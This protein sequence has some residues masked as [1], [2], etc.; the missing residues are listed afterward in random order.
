MKRFALGSSAAVSTALLWVAPLC[1]IAGATAGIVSDRWDWVPLTLLS[2]GAGALLLWLILQSRVSGGFWGRRST[3]MSTNAILTVVAVIALLGVVNVLGN[4][5]SVDIDLTENQ[6]FTL[7]VETRDVLQNLKEPVQVLVFDTNAASRDRLLLEQYRRHANNRF[8]F[9]FVDPQ[10][11]P[12]LAR[13]YN[14]TQVGQVIVKAGTKTQRIDEDLSES[15]LTPALIRVTSDRTVTAYFTT[16]HNELPLTGGSASLSEVAKLLEQR[17][18]ELLPLNLLEKGKVPEDANVIVVAGPRQPFLRLEEDLLK[19]YLNRG[20]SLLLMLDV[21]VNVGLADLLK[22]WGLTL[23]NRWVIDGS[24]VGQQVGL[25]PDTIIVTTYG[26]H[27]ITQRFAQ[28]PSVFPRAQAIRI[29]P[30]KDDDIVELALSGSQTWAETDWQSGNLEFTEGVDTLGPLPLAVAITRTLSEEP[31]KQARLVVFGDSEFATDGVIAYQ[32]INS[33]L[34][35]NS[36]LWLGDRDQQALSLR[37][38]Q[39]TNRRLQLNVTTSRWIEISAVLLLPLLGFG[40]AVFLWW[41][42]R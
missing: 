4:R 18:V 13:Q 38:R 16:G 5:Y 7:A 22:D 12:S 27:P 14:V 6:S 15:N 37:P 8:S 40:L 11:Q 26:N 39:T 25:G 9:E 30:V 1:L 34:F 35:V 36:V 24:G 19:N 41:R 3:Q 29:E 23:D 28:G 2:V 20:G 10:A 33:D 42:R 21:D 17:D 32:G 31:A